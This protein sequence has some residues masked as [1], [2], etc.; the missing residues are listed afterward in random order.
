MH[1]EYESLLANDTW[2]L[3][4]IPKE[5]NLI[6]CRWVYKLK[7]AADGSVNRFKARLVAKGFT[8]KKGV[9][10]HETFSPIVKFDSIRTLLS[11]AAVED[12]NITQFDIRTAYL[13]GLLRELIYMQQPIGF[14]VG[15]PA[16][17]CL[18]CRLNKA[19]YGLKQGAQV[20]NRKF[21][22]FLQAYDLIVSDADCC[23]YVNKLDPK[24]IL[25]IWVDDGMVCS[26]FNDSIIEILHCMEGAFQITQGLAEVYVGLH[27][28]RDRERGLIHIDQHQ[29]LKQ[30]LRR[31]NHEDCHHV[32][33]PSNP[34]SAARM[35]ISHATDPQVTFPYKECI[36]C[37]Q[38]AHIGTRFDISYAVSNM[39]HFNNQP[40]MAHVSGVKRILKYIK[41]TLGHTITYG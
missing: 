11:V 33:V 38:F 2:T 31:F 19:L 25:C 40:T 21:N 26:T 34:S 6:K 23:I 36:G 35:Q 15:H 24:L 22:H 37:L 32:A 3:E 8:Q 27:I 39:S 30:V 29:Y 1:E 41:G 7:L 5:C 9:D 20:W 14:E 16:N 18:V 10:Y 4:E 28:T 12:L 13:N 17:R